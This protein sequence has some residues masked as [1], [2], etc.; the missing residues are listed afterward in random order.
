MLQNNIKQLRTQL[1][2]TQRELAYMVGTSQQQIQR[3]ETGKVAA[4]LGLAQAICNALDKPLNIVFPKSGQLI[5][6]FH[7]KHRK[8]D[9]DLEAI[10]TSGIEMD[11]SLWTVKLWLQG[12]QD[13]LLL[14]IAA[15]DKR[16]FH[17]Y[18]Q[19]I[20][21]PN[22]ERFFVFDSDQYRYALNMREVV[23][24]QFL[25]D[26]LPPIVA[27]EDDDYEDDYFNVHITL[28]NGGPVIPLSVEPDALQNEETDDIGQLNAFFEQLD[29]EPETTDRYM[30]TDEDGED[31]FIRIGSIAMVRVVLDALE[32]VEEDEE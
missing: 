12:Q 16:R 22:V 5:N 15:A 27:E 30:L 7:K 9:E 3:I 29:C 2:I 32:P 18:F 31:A 17:Y 11:S 1:S 20:A 23:F 14:P 24:H 13:Y 8:T 19:E 25:S 21:S 28:V 26:G 10:A 6:D 4:K